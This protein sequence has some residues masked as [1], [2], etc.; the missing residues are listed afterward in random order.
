MSAWYMLIRVHDHIWADRHWPLR[1][2]IEA[3]QTV[4][5]LSILIH[6]ERSP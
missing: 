1:V 3:C 2:R 6:L 4:F 5:K